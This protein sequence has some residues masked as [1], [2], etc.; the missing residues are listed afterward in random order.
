M[1]RVG[2]HISQVQKW[3]WQ[4]TCAQSEASPQAWY[5]EAG[6]LVT[7]RCAFSRLYDSAK[8]QVGTQ[9]LDKFQ[10]CEWQIAILGCI[11]NFQGLEI[12]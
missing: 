11:N 1:L 7:H 6:T 5:S 10:M 2:Q 9:E 3:D 8:E 4:A 12:F